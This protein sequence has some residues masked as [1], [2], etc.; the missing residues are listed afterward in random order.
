MR[1]SSNRREA[2]VSRVQDFHPEEVAAVR[3]NTWVCIF[4]FS[5]RTY[6]PWAASGCTRA[7][8]GAP[9]IM[10]EGG[11]L[12]TRGMSR[13]CQGLLCIFMHACGT[14]VYVC[15]ERERERSKG[16]R[17]DDVVGSMI[18][19]TVGYYSRTPVVGI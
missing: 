9:V 17:V 15:G 12:I 16:P 2:R 18:P 4:F 10:W 5:F 1:S 7:S 11:R 8:G 6:T 19:P 14:C 13:A 3:G